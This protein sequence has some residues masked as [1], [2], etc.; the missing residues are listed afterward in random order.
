MHTDF[1]CR[2][3]TQRPRER[4][5]G[6]FFSRKNLCAFVAGRVT[7]K[8]PELVVTVATTLLQRI[9]GDRLFAD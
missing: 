6:Y 3:R 9:G 7:F 2:K 5:A 1:F 4:L 8:V